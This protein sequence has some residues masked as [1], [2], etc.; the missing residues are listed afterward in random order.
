MLVKKGDLTKLGVSPANADKYHANLNDALTQHHIDTPLRI[1]HFLAQVLHES[2]SMRRVKENLKYSAKRLLEV[3]PKYFKTPEQAKRCA[4][5]E[6]KIANKVYGGRLGNGK[7]STGDGFR[8]RGR[9]LIQLTGKNNYQQ[10]SDWIDVD[11]VSKPD[12]VAS[13]YAVHSAVYFWTSR[14]INEPADADDIITVT[15]K[16]NGGH[17]GLEARNTSL[18]NAKELFGLPA[19]EIP[20]PVTV[21]DPT[22]TVTVSPSLR[23]RKQPKIGK[24]TL[25]GSLPKGSKVNL[26]KKA[27]VPGWVQVQVGL[28]GKL[29]TG[30]VSSDYLKAL[31]KPKVKKAPK[32]S[33]PKVLTYTV[34]ASSS[35][36]LRNAP[37]GKGGKVIGSLPQGTKVKKVKDAQV[38]GWM[39]VQAMLKGKLVRG[40]VSAK[41]LKPLPS[42]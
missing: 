39:E 35:L 31:P 18:N 30:F 2:G 34:T 40:F 37:K 12:P 42:K 28:K 5:D 20:P 38:K 9:G 16:V 13:D 19:R 15:E 36:R 8:Y 27:D 1:C 26:L 14:H 3:F 10:F 25:M 11:L 4:G 21:P 24:A 22:H 32:P 29:V 17:H 41:Y 6:R 7:E 33:S 23:I